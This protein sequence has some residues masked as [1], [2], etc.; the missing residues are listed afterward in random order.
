[1]KITDVGILVEPENIK[2]LADA[3]NKLHDDKE[4]RRRFEI[5]G[6]L[7]VQK[8][9]NWDRITKMYERIYQE[10]GDE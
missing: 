4:L 8:M 10:V 1:M 3:I 9:C 2:G 6:R 5:N 7:R